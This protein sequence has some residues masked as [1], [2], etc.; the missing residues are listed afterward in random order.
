M[1]LKQKISTKMQTQ[2]IVLIE[3]STGNV[4]VK[5]LFHERAHP[6]PPS[7]CVQFLT[8][9]KVQTCEWSWLI[10]QAVWNGCE[11]QPVWPPTLIDPV[12]FV[13]LS[14]LL[15]PE[16]CFSY[17]LNGYGNTDPGE[18]LQGLETLLVRCPTKPST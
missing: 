14:R 18:L 6:H 3:Q 2:S 5:V 17:Q 12:A 4:E 7:E 13:T 11:G 10:D 15:N 9:K 16:P 8:K 1:T